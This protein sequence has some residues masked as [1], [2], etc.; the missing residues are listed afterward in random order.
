MSV[1]TI[2]AIG[3]V[4]MLD[5][6]NLR[7]A[8][9]SHRKNKRLGRGPGSRLGRTA[10]KGNK[11]QKARKSGGI[12]PGFEGGQMPLY[13]RLP[14]RG[15]DNPFRIDYNVINIGQLSCFGGGEEVTALTLCQKNLVKNPGNPIKLLGKGKVNVSLTITVNKASAS[16]RAA[17]EQA[18]GSVQEI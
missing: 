14:K 1:T 17:I 4:Y 16:A 10:G 12:R 8:R 6:S 11:G 7:P 3:G 9:G 5:L 18:G 15:F 2:K 13:R